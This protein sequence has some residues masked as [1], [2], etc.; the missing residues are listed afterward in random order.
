[1]NQSHATADDKQLI[2]GQSDILQLFPLKYRW[3]W[4]HYLD[5]NQNHWTPLDIPVGPDVAQWKDEN[6]PTAYRHR[7]ET[8]MAQLT[9]F[10]IQR[11]IDIAESLTNLITAP[12]VKTFLYRQAEEETRH[13]WSYQYCIEN[14]GIDEHY[15]YNLYR[16]VPELNARVQYA[17][18]FSNLAEAITPE[19]L[20][21]LN[22]K[23]SFL[24][25]L[26]FWYLGFEG[27][28]FYLNL[29]GPVQSLARQGYFSATAEQFQYILRDENT[30]IQFGIDLIR[31]FCHEYPEIWDAHTI[32][33]IKDIMRH[34][35]ELEFDFIKYVLK[36]PAIDYNVHD[37]I[38]MAYWLVNRRLQSI[39]IYEKMYPDAKC[40]MPWMSEMIELKKEKNFF[41]TRVTEYRVA[42][43]NKDE[44]TGVSDIES[45]L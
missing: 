21:T 3:A 37:H 23:K 12:E 8:V 29:A 14:M 16:T 32:G 10:D 11:A 25:I 44:I 22:G 6:L 40:T 38:E 20:N 17:Q 5:S 4:E 24:F 18:E 39:G 19:V 43:L 31:E 45:V 33:A 41:E 15:I 2:L 7:F 9:T 36:E 34:V 28:W 26:V 30:H 27:I 42:S 35:V 13:T 1:M